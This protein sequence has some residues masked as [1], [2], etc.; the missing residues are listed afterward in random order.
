MLPGSPNQRA[1]MILEETKSKHI[2]GSGPV[3]SGKTRPGVRGLV[4]YASR[5]FG[6]Y[7]WF[8]ASPSEKQ[9]DGV[10]GDEARLW[11]YE[12]NVQ[13][14]RVR[15]HWELPS[16]VPGAAPNRFWQ[17][18][19]TDERSATRAASFTFAG[20]L[21]D[22]TTDLAERL[23][24]ILMERTVSIQAAKSLWFMNPYGPRHPYKVKY[25]DRLAKGHTWLKFQ[26]A[27]NPSLPPEAEEE[28]LAIY[29]P[30]PERQRRVYGE[31]AAAEGLIY[32]DY[33]RAVRRRL[34]TGVR[35]LFVALDH[36]SASVTCGHLIGAW[37]GGAH[38]LD[39]FAYDA[40]ISVPLS[41]R[42][43]AEMYVERYGAGVRAWIV[44]PQAHGF[45]LALAEELA[46]FGVYGNVIAAEN[47]LNP[48]IQ[49]TQRWLWSGRLTIDP[50]H[51]EYLETDLDT[52]RWDAKAA[53]EGVEKPLKLEA[54][55]VDGLRYFVATLVMAQSDA[56][57]WQGLNE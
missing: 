13:F 49:I 26:L 52:Y 48:G 23:I 17:V 25:L 34:L 11:A 44:D 24:S 3:R 46:K 57:Q 55:A 9:W 40:R 15:G 18:L 16:W 6:G 8:L 14:K 4:R 32:S 51:C 30:G 35:A 28:L 2:H 41:D 42:A 29:P 50:D 45:R 33:M 27:D 43:L 10:L 31:W 56:A 5:Y 38:V 1:I 12:H 47:D 7:D 37:S 39:T 36:G 20:G 54:H 21:G 22:E 19:G 53:R